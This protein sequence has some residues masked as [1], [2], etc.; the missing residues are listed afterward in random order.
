[1]SWDLNSGLFEPRACPPHHFILL[2]GFQTQE[3]QLRGRWPHPG[4][5]VPPR[6]PLFLICTL[7]TLK[8]QPMSCWAQTVRRMMRG[9]LVQTPHFKVIKPSRVGGE[10]GEGRWLVQG[11]NT[12]QQDSQ[13]WR[14]FQ[15]PCPL[16]HELSYNLNKKSTGSPIEKKNSLTW[17]SICHFKIW[18][19]FID[20]KIKRCTSR[21]NT[22]LG[23]GE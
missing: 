6:V 17:S 2:P 13:N 7:P 9:H 4:C 21:K 1:M 18:R 23:L 10:V 22:N 15:V 19:C 14:P 5:C 20:Y 8:L 11:H 16:W 12:R 3:T